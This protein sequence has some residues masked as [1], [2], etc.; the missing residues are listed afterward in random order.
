MHPQIAAAEA[1]ADLDAFLTVWTTYVRVRDAGK[2]DSATA[3]TL[4]LC[5]T[6]STIESESPCVW[7]LGEIVRMRTWARG[8]PDDQ[9]S[10]WASRDSSQ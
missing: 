4:L 5:S 1:A 3:A 2:A 6:L 8:T 7:P 9:E 10:M